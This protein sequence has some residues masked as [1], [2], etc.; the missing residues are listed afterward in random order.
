MSREDDEITEERVPCVPDRPAPAAPPSLRRPLLEASPALVLV[1]A[2]ALLLGPWWGGPADFAP[3][4]R[5][6]GEDAAVPPRPPLTPPAAGGAVVPAEVVE[7]PAEPAPDLPSPVEKAAPPARPTPSAAAPVARSAPADMPTPKVAAAPVTPSP[8]GP[9]VEI[10]LTSRPLGEPV[11][12]D[13]RPRGATPLRLTLSPG[14]HRIA[15]G[16]D[17]AVGTEIT[18]GDGEKAL[19]TYLASEG[20]IR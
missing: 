6:R 3:V 13:G 11:T 16:A 15:F 12:V 18:V 9:P 2:L 1:A 14:S 8:T 7:P 10:T 17:G 20:A 19:W 5:L 4:P